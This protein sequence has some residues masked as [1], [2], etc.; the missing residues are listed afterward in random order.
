MGKKTFTN[1]IKQQM[2]DAY[3][4]GDKK[5]FA[6]IYKGIMEPVKTSSYK[7]CK[8]NKAKSLYLEDLEWD[9]MDKKDFLEWL[10]NLSDRKRV[11]DLL[12]DDLEKS[13][14]PERAVTMLTADNLHRLF[15]LNSY[16]I[17]HTDENNVKSVKDIIHYLAKFKKSKI[18]ASP[19]TL[20]RD[21]KLLAKLTG[22]ENYHKKTKIPYEISGDEVEAC[23]ETG[24]YYTDDAKWDCMEFKKKLPVPITEEQMAALKR[25][26]EAAQISNDKERAADLQVLSDLAEIFIP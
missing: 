8:N 26:K 16:F 22:C 13:K 12:A 21:L 17:N 2:Q 10:L 9:L 5:T 6:A 20:Y 23:D 14:K 7:D 18:E 24:Y 1:E 19:A 11:I 25:L 15:V 4:A 3:D